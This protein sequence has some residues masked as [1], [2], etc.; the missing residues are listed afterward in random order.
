MRRPHDDDGGDEHVGDDGNW[1]SVL[2]IIG[3]RKVQVLMM[4]MFMIMSW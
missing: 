2:I 3:V 4:V 1:T